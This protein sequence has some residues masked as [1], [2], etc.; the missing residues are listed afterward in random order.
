M[1]HTEPCQQGEAATLHSNQEKACATLWR[2]WQDG[3]V[4][5]ALP[6]EMVPATRADGYAI[7]AHFESYSAKP[8]AGWK[9]AAT[10][11]A[12][13]THI[14]VDGPLAG[15]L[16]A[17]RLHGSGARLSIAGNRMRVCEPEFGFRF[18]DDLPPRERPYE[19]PEVMAAVA[20]LHLTLE[21]P[22]S[23][24][25]DFTRVGGPSLI[26]DNACARDLVVGEPVA[27]DWRTLDLSTQPVLARVAGRYD[28][29]GAGA[30]VLGGPAIA[31]TWLV[32]ELS[33][34]GIGA[35]RGELVT[36]GTCMV[37]LEIEPGD[38]IEV[39]Y[40]DLGSIGVQIEP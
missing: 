5:D 28:R 15:R 23:R 33:G 29:E 21:L 17:E 18:G 26:A 9:I 32:N 20:D 38:R 39:D 34:L 8:L 2:H 24:Y 22:D 31:L 12:G 13:Q 37:P 16:L 36:T 11:A 35:R 25:T 27:A 14:N 3:T 10:S 4:L 40:G 6:A 7:Q 1:T 19:I 30:N